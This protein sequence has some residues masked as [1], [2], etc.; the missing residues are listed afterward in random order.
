M[1]QASGL[2][3]LEL[4]VALCIAAILAGMSVLNQ[5]ALRPSLD[6]AQATRQVLLDLRLARMLAVT[7]HSSR[8]IVF[9]AGAGTYQPQHRDGDGFQDDG[10]PVLLPAG[11][12]V[13]D[14]SGSDHAIGFGPRGSAATFGTITVENSKGEMRHVVVDI[15]GD[16]RAD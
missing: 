4:L 7:S 11:I 1:A 10:P 16:I 12:V 2:S 8:R 14:C 3:L 6:L 9:V 13:A 15:A 5:R